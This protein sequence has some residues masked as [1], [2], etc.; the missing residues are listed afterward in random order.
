MTCE[1]SLRDEAASVESTAFFGMW[2]PP[3]D[4]LVM[5]TAAILLLA[6]LVRAASMRLLPGTSLFRVDLISRLS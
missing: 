6:W 4:L 3:V 2:S 1:E 5:V